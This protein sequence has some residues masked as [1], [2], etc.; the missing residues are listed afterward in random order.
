MVEKWTPRPMTLHELMRK[1]IDVWGQSDF[2]RGLN[3]PFNRDGDGQYATAIVLGFHRVTG[4]LAS[5]NAGHL[6]P[7]WYHASD[8][9]RGWLEEVDPALREAF[10]LPVGLIPGI[11]AIYRWHHGRGERRGQGSRAGTASRMGS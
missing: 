6:P 11:G 7:S 9:A 8:R 10:G 5:S 1:N 2:M 3:D 4:H